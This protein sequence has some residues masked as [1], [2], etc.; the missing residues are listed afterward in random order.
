MKINKYSALRFIVLIGIVNMFADMTYEGSR[1]ITGPFMGLLGASALTIS[2]TAGLGEFFGYSLRFFTG[3][4]ADKTKKYWL[5]AFVGYAINMLAVPALALAGNWPMAAILIIAER[6]GRAIRRPAVEAMLSYTAKEVGAGKVFG[7]NEALDQTGATIGP[8]IVAL[9]LYL[10]GGYKDGFAILLISALLCLATLVVARIMFAN[11]RDLSLREQPAPLQTK[12]Y[13]KAFW[14]FVLA[15]ALIATGA[16][17]FALISYHFQQVGS[18]TLHFIPLFYAVAMATG[19]ITALFFGR[20]YDKIGIHSVTIAFFIATFSLPL[21]IFG[22]FWIAL[23]G[24][25]LWGVGLGAQ[26]TLLK[27]VLVPEVPI[28]KRSTAFGIFDGI[29]GITWLLGN[30]PVGILYSISLPAVVIFSMLFQFSALPVFYLADHFKN[31]I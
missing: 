24:I 28:D 4:L 19:A 17:D 26:D 22:G 8:L 10:K 13:S 30:I 12:G 5:S 15:G 25:A 2:I 21:A 18:V 7:I 3:Y 31:H 27:A 20:L 1:S 9:V 11:P 16:T 6:T 29:Y 23:I 14:L